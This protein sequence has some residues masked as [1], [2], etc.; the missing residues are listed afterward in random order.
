A[1]PLPPPPLALFPQ[2]AHRHGG[3]GHPFRAAAGAH[4]GTAGRVPRN[5]PG[6]HRAG[7]A[8]RERPRRRRQLRHLRVPGRGLPRHR[9]LRPDPR[10]AGRGAPAG[11]LVRRQVRRRGNHPLA[12][13]EAAQAPARPRQPGRLGDPRRLR[14]H[15]AAPRVP[16]LAGG[17]APLA[18]RAADQPRGLRR[19]RAPLGAGLHRRRGLEPERGGQAVVRQD[20]VAPVLPQ[21]V[22]RTGKRPG[23]AAPLR[24][25]GFL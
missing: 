17:D 6:L 22:G 3:E 4:L 19:R 14:Q 24:R 12:L 7:A 10:R 2:G 5:E 8:R 1:P 16:G 21:P 9:P 20:E 23:A 18:G 15:A 11:R 25:P 13:R